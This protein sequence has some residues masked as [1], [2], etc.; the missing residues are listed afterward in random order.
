MILRRYFTALK[1]AA[2]L[3]ILALIVFKVRP[4]EIVSVLRNMDTGLLGWAAL[5]LIPNL[6]IQLLKWGYL[7]K[8]LKPNVTVAEIVSSLFVGMSL[9]AVSP[10]RSG[11]LMRGLCIKDQSPAR[12]AGL[13]LIDKLSS[14]AVTLIAAIL[15]L[16]LL[17]PYIIVLPG[18][19][20]IS[21]MTWGCFNV[22]RLGDKLKEK[23]PNL[24]FKEKIYPLLE[25]FNVLNNRRILYI[26]I[27]S[28]L[29]NL[30]FFA[31]FYLLVLSFTDIS[32]K[33]AAS[34]IPSIF[35]I[36]SLLPITFVDL[37]VREAVS[38]LLLS[39]FNVEGVYAF[40]AAFMLFLIDVAAPGIV[41]SVLIL[42]LKPERTH[43]SEDR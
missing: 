19:A 30:T 3:G 2:S 14:F 33:A 32:L 5:L 24:P 1:I 15:G 17:Y 21:V 26:L 41:G 31:Q 36:K 38:V 25:S 13:A 18:L 9:G 6:L 4:S 11:E 35:V 43:Y 8:T 16:I 42:T 40:N 12:I 20:V 10:A 39:N 37:G 34:V 29:F 7:A 27:L 22:D 23:F 28:V